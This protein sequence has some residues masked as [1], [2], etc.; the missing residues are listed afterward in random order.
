MQQLGTLLDDEE[1]LFFREAA[2]AKEVLFKKIEVGL[3]VRLVE[4]EL[5]I[6]RFFPCRRLYVYENI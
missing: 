6:G 1:G 5:V 3:L 2:L 4:E